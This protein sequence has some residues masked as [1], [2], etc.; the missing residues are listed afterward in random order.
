[1]VLAPVPVDQGDKVCLYPDAPISGSKWGIYTV[2]GTS[3]GNWS[4][5]DSLN[6]CWDTTGF[7]PGLYI[8]KL[9]LTYIDG[10]ETT[11]WKKVI[12]KP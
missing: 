8:V 12:V 3:V 4:F 7:A 11:A 5:S 10:H 1:V 9:T 2:M 6:N